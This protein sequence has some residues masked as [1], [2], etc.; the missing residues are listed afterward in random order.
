MALFAVASAAIA[1]AV[2]TQMIDLVVRVRILTLVGLLGAFGLALAD[3]VPELQP[4]QPT[5]LD[6]QV[7]QLKREVLE[8]NRD[9]SLL[10]QEL[11]FPSNSQFAGT[12]S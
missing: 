10:E 9:L 5:P 12:T 4:G 6:Q 3:H 1:P 7:Q 11:L 2:E 8:I